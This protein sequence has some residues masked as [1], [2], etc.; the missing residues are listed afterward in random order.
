MHR[1]TCL[2]NR[3]RNPAVAINHADDRFTRKLGK[4]AS[5]ENL[6]VVI[7]GFEQAAF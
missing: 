6:N 4:R 7:G 3:A 2:S 1:S 5:L